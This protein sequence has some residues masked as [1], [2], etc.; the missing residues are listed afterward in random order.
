MQLSSELEAPTQYS[1]LVITP[2]EKLQQDLNDVMKVLTKKG[3]SGV[4]VSLN[5]PYRSI[6]QIFSDNKID[7][8][9]VFYIDCIASKEA[10]AEKVREVLHID[11]PTDLRL[12]DDSIKS[13]LKEMPG[14][15]YVVIDALSTLLIYNDK[16]E[17]AKFVKS[18]TEHAVEFKVKTVALS[19]KTG[20]NELLTYIFNFFDKVIQME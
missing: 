8:G 7:T 3:I 18:L 2:L 14:E 19:P 5:K 9:K 1:I 13:Y 17:V 6:Q 20:D 4:Y 11:D 12:L 16:K 15:K 10:K